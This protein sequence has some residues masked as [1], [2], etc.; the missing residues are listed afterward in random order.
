LNDYLKNAASCAF[1]FHSQPTGE[2]VIKPFAADH[3]GSFGEG[4]ASFSHDGHLHGFINSDGHIVIAPQFTGM[5]T[6]GFKAGLACVRAG[7]WGYINKSGNFVW[8]QAPETG[9][10]KDQRTI[11]SYQQ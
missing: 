1:T 5:S 2:E 10:K 6:G 3:V 11:F 4:F 7:F 9:A 8:K